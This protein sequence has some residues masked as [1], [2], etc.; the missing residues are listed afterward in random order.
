MSENDQA[1]DPKE[2]TRALAARANNLALGRMD[3]Q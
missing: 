2:E 1:A 3:L